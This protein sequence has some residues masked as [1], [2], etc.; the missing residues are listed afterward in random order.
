MNWDRVAG[1]WKQFKGRAKQ[2]WG[3]LTD[4]DLDVAAGKRDELAGKVQERYGVAK[5]EAERQ[6]DTRPAGRVPSAPRSRAPPSRFSRPPASNSSRPSTRARSTAPPPSR[7]GRASDGLRPGFGAGY[8]P[9]CSRMSL[10]RSSVS[11]STSTILVA[12]ALR[13]AS[14]REA[15]S[16]GFSRNSRAP[17]L[18]AS[19][20]FSTVA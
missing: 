12:L 3:K 17:S 5:D 4:D 6:V 18:I 16:T 2:Q 13:M 7:S 15:R 19:T 20:P 9:L 8:Q 10:I 14:V 11:F 1:N